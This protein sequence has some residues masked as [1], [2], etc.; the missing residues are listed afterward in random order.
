LQYYFGD[1]NFP[2]DKFLQQQAQLDDG[3]V[4][5]EV[6]LKCA[7]LKTLTEDAATV[8][9]A[10]SKSKDSLLE[11]SEDKTKVRRSRPAPDVNEEAQ[12]ATKSRTVY[13]KGFPIDEQLDNLLE[14]FSKYGDCETVLV[15]FMIWPKAAYFYCCVCNFKC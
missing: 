12:L 11:V 3:W 13:C 15:N 4:P 6:M 1:Y 14:Y 5:L 10:L 7:R 2:R 8:I 9:L